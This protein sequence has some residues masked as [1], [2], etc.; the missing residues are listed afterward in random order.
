MPS[1]NASAHLQS[2]GWAGPGH[3]LNSHKKGS[4]RAGLAYDP[5]SP[6]TTKSS[7]SSSYFASGGNGLIKPLLVSKKSDNLG[8]GRRPAA[9][10][11]QR[12]NE[13]W[14][15]GFEAALAGTGT[16]SVG[17]AK[18][19]TADEELQR[20][21]NVQAG[22]F[23]GL[24]GFFVRGETVGGTIGSDAEEE[25]KT[26]RGRKRKSDDEGESD[27][28]TGGASKRRKK[29]KKSEKPKRKRDGE[30]ADAGAQAEV[31]F[32]QIAAFMSVRDQKPSSSS[33]SSSSLLA[34]KRS[35]SEEKKKKIRESE[36]FRLAGQWLE[37]KEGK[38]KSK[39]TSKSTSRSTPTSNHDD[40]CSE[41]EEE[42]EA[43]DDA[44]KLK[45]KSKSRRAK[46]ERR[47]ITDAH[48]VQREET[49]EERRVRRA[50]KRARRKA[51][52]M[53]MVAG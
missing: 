28:T 4:S 2:L 13:W 48:G 51:E 47:I 41:K 3:P 32:S 20:S 49:K 35:K 40:E 53:E 44:A 12:G 36:Q 52:E 27:S 17:T 10:E 5:S 37:I 8:L 45:E 15:K 34:A 23:G 16:G 9:H 30:N 29:D 19:K 22:R 11:P 7:S 26:K 38:T 46:R 21:V 6:S 33:S 42:E 18:K 43:D 39:P 50:V 24:Y 31:Q 14:L 25:L 1:L